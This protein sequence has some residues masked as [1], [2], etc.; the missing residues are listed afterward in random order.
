MIKKQLRRLCFV[1]GYAV[2]MTN[3]SA[4]MMPCY[5]K[6][7]GDP[8]QFFPE[9]TLVGPAASKCEFS[10]EANRGE[11]SA[12]ANLRVRLL[13][14]PKSRL[15][16]WCRHL[17]ILWSCVRDADLVCTHLPEE[18]G[19]LTAMICRV[20]KKPLLVQVLGDWKEAILVSGPP[21]RI[22]ILKSWISELMNSFTVRTAALIFTQGHELF[23]KAALLN[24]RAVKSAIAQTTLD[25]DTFFERKSVG[26]HEPLRI[27]TVC[28][29]EQRKGLDLLAQAIQ[30]LSE[31]G[32]RIEW[33]CVGRGPSE[34]RLRS[35][36]SSLGISN[37]VRFFGYVPLG[38]CLFQ[39]YRE[40]DVFILPSF[41][42]GV[43]YAML[44]AMAHSLPVIC[45]T[46]GG[47]SQVLTNG[48]EGILVL[49]GRAD[50][51]A[52]AIGCVV[53]DPHLALRMGQAGF[54]KARE[55]RSTFILPAHRSVIEETFGSIADVEGSPA[56]QHVSVNL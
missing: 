52:D 42:E 12:M 15:W 27:L 21:G 45:T 5:L 17:P 4:H 26:L 50:L 1:V 53:N 18:L 35:L 36:I 6:A 9:V 23:E 20:M 19:F 40:A 54:R 16:R 34:Q 38:R 30:R 8:C 43:S 33:W 31:G 11:L 56:L 14:M 10:E 7:I 51:I 39:L 2:G 41:H 28:G 46:V 44:E 25:E 47:T 37:F 29:L 24:P 3:K 49:P 13:P 48:K 22:R 32:V 55:F